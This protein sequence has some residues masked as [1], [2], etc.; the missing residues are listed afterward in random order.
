MNAFEKLGLDEG[1]LI[2]APLAGVTDHP[3]RRICMRN[4]AH[5]SY[6]EMLSAS[7]LCYSSKR[8]FEMMKRHDEEMILGVQLTGKNAEETAKA[9]AILD[10]H[11]FDTIDINMGCPVKKIVKQGCGSAI[12][13]DPERVYQTVKMGR[14]ETDKV[15]TVKIRLGWQPS[16]KNMVEVAQAAEQGGAEWITVHGRT[17]DDDYSVPVD[18]DGIR[19]VADAVE[20]PVIGNG[21][22][23]TKKDA[24]VMLAKTGAKGV[25]VSRGALGDPWVFAGIKGDRTSL[26]LE[27]WSEGVHWHIAAQAEEYGQTGKGAICMRKHLIWYS[28]GWPGGKAFREKMRFMETV[29]DCHKAVDEF[30][31]EIEQ[32]GVSERDLSQNQELSSRFSW[33]PKWDMD[34]GL[35]RGVGH[36]VIN[37]P[38]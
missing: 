11:P 16:E 32:L 14:E 30:V 23:F 6:V 19:A 4:G 12:L 1:A 33:D 22:V 28:K 37:T 9:I 35:D 24:E 15:F 25:M 3:F 17:R 27:E 38:L 7:A 36:E 13:R 20:I 34:R 10:R 5:L 18:L 26:S 21:N 31:S 8:T 29:D 2:L